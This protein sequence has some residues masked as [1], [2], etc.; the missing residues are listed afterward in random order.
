[1]CIRHKQRGISLIEL[2]MFIVIVSVALAGIL[3][4]MNKTTQGSADPIVHKQALAIA[5]SLLEEIELMPFTYCDPND[6]NAQTALAPA[7]ACAVAANEE[8]TVIGPEAG[9]ARLNPV[10]PFDNVSDYH[11]FG[12]ASGA[13]LDITGLNTGL[14]G[15]TLQPIVVTPVATLPNV[16]TNDALLITVTVVGPDNLPV[17]VEGIRTRYAPRATP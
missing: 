7:G 4:V 10:T 14:S 9:E 1:M 11:G 3:L 15:Y 6:A 8:S 5:E 16:A 2:I 13:I 12:M 17:V